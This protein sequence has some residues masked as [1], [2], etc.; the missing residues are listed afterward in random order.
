MYNVDESFLFDQPTLHS[1]ALS[2]KRYVQIETAPL[3]SVRVHDK[4]NSSK[5]RMK[6]STSFLPALDAKDSED[7]VRSE[8]YEFVT[9]PTLD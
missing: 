2:D 5:R 9:V 7:D 8:D 4:P 6:P 1:A 3:A